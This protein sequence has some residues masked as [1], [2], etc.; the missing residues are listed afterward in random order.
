MHYSELSTEQNRA[1]DG[2]SAAWK[3]LHELPSDYF[4]VALLLHH[5]LI[6]SFITTLHLTRLLT[7]A[8]PPSFEPWP[9]ILNYLIGFFSG[10]QILVLM[11][12]FVLCFIFLF[13]VF[14]LSLLHLLY[15]AY[16]PFNIPPSAPSSSPCL[17]LTL[18]CSQ[19]PPVSQA[20]K[21]TPL[22][23]LQRVHDLQ[24]QNPLLQE[25]KA[26]GK[27]SSGYL[28]LSFSFFSFLRFYCTFCYVKT[29]VLWTV[30]LCF[31]ITCRQIQG[32]PTCKAICSQNPHNETTKSTVGDEN[33]PSGCL[34]GGGAGQKE[35]NLE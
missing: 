10:F 16:V 2:D 27:F 25:P 17:C 30:P 34:G 29:F 35:L 9:L 33:D 15:V 7:T 1:I 13:L 14:I 20:A 24:T 11:L 3:S 31:I 32:F 23:S 19:R 18:C 6:L 21:G 22:P 4:Y 12:I 28:S 5:L 8:F 26:R